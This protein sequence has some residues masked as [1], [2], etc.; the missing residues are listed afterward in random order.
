MLLVQPERSSDRHRASECLRTGHRTVPLIFYR[1]RRARRYILRVTDEG[2]A[3]VTIPRS[4]SKD[5]ARIF[6]RQHIGWVQKQLQQLDTRPRP[7]QTLAPGSEI[8]FRGSKAVLRMSAE[9]QVQGLQRGAAEGA[10]AVLFTARLGPRLDLR[11]ALR[12]HFWRLAKTEFIPR[13]FEL[14]FRHGIKVKRVL[15]RNQRSRWG[16]CSIHGTIC[17]NWRLIQ[18]PQ[19]VR[20]YLIIHEL[21]HLREMNH[22]S[23]F[24]KHVAAA[25]PR[26]EEAE[27]WLDDHDHLLRQ[28]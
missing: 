9:G 27:Q 7:L 5:A 25:C 21:M 10:N 15:V 19:F 18:G 28:G 6:A 24:W 23:R 14:A 17:L 2:A 11:A 8:L 16:S 3:R 12:L 22:S 1:S 26:Y 20:D 13:V 4:G